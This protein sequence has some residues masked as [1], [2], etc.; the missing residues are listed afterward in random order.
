M[1]TDTYLSQLD[2]I[3]S[4]AGNMQRQARHDDLSDLP[5]PERQALVTRALSAIARISGK[6]SSYSKD[7]QRVIAHQP[8][9]HM[10]TPQIVGIVA[11]LRSDVADGHL[12]SLVELVHADVFAD[13]LEMAENLIQSGYK[14]A[15]AVITGS[16]LEGH[17]RALCTKHAIAADET[18]PDGAIVQK[19]ADRLNSELASS[20]V[21]GKLDQKS[22][23]AWLDLRNKA[24]HGHHVEFSD[25]QT[26]LMLS[27]VRDLISR[28]PA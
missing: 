8:Y 5:E 28:S 14:V 19:K 27:G 15:S 18:K 9:L 11:A 24:A 17:L 23:T 21:Y 26:V 4:A 2:S 12:A 3:L 20:E 22:I 1:Q 7:A 16:A 25:E 6:D 13:F 10:H